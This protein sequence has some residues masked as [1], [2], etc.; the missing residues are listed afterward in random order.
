MRTLVI[1]S[2]DKSDIYFANQLTKR[3]NVVGIVVENQIPERDCSSLPRKAMKYASRP[4]LFLAKVAEV[5][6]RR[7]VE[8]RQA[9]NYPGNSLDFGGDD[10]TLQPGEGVNVLYT[11][12]PNDINRAEYREWVRDQNPDIIAVCGASILKSDMLSIP[13]HGVLNLHGGLAQFYRGLF[14]T[15][16][17]IH[18]S[19][20]ECIGATVHFVSEGVDDGDVVYQGRP[21]IEERDNPNTLY[22]KVVELGVEMMARAIWDIEHGRCHSTPL[23]SKGRLYL[24]EDFNLAAKRRTWRKVADGV[25]SDYLANKAGRDQRVLDSL[26]NDFDAVKPEAGSTVS[27]ST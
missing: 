13:G 9:Y 2:Q 4:G 18:N 17:A 6:D 20:P 12:G 23:I 25:L 14:T 26:I 27:A 21:G 19:E 11:R 22:R 24:N 10:R 3:L 7:F 15:D 5:L 16:W 1:V 8:P